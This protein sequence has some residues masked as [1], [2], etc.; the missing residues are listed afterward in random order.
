[1]NKGEMNLLLRGWQKVFLS[2][3]VA[4]FWSILKEEKKKRTKES[5]VFHVI[6]HNMIHL[7]DFD[8]DEIYFWFLGNP[9]NSV[10]TWSCLIDTKAPKTQQRVNLL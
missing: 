4:L 10:K 3:S 2:G 6:L 9:M 1:M 5:C 7:G 8:S